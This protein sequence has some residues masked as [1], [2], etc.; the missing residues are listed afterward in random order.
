MRSF[1]SASSARIVLRGG[2]VAI[3][4]L[5]LF[6]FAKGVV[7]LGTSEALYSGKRRAV[8]VLTA[9]HVQLARL[10][11]IYG[12][13]YASLEREKPIWRDRVG[14]PGSVDCG[15]A[16]EYPEQV[17]GILP[18]AARTDMYFVVGPEPI[19]GKD[20][21]AIAILYPGPSID[22]SEVLRSAEL[23]NLFGPSESRDENLLKEAAADTQM[24][25]IRDDQRDA[26]R[27]FIERRNVTA[28]STDCRSYSFT[29]FEFDR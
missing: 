3:A 12:E 17:L 14:Q 25:V 2:A 10:G 16:I 28:V 29:V 20:R 22:F 27:L 9:R 23:E 26:F 7:V 4:L 21:E 5:L 13:V 18:L 11:T 24:R 15:L 1:L 8:I 6:L 19:A